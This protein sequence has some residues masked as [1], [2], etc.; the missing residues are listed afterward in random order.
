MEMLRPMSLG[1]NIKSFG[2]TYFS[3]YNHCTKIDRHDV[4]IAASRIG[5]Y[6]E[7]S[8]RRDP[9]LA[10]CFQRNVQSGMSL[11]CG[12]TRFPHTDCTK[13]LSLNSEGGCDH[14]SF[15]AS[16]SSSM[17]AVLCVVTRLVDKCVAEQTPHLRLPHIAA[18][19]ETPRRK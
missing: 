5:V 17:Q 14:D 15:P 10:R 3:R 1:F 16:R 11:S 7:C 9:I 19:K 18:S 13:K 8:E 12:H 6:A 4:M 2:P